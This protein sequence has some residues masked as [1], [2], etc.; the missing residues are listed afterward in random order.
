M[1]KLRARGGLSKL[2]NKSFYRV[3]DD[4]WKWFWLEICSNDYFKNPM[5][6]K[7]FKKGLPQFPEQ[8]SKIEQAYHLIHSGLSQLT[9]ELGVIS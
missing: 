9:Q 2:K 8:P 4:G 3:T 1:N 7:T 6:S 5:I